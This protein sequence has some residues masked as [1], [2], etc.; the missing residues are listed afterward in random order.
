MGRLMSQR[1]MRKVL[2]WAHIHKADDSCCVRGAIRTNA[3]AKTE[4]DQWEKGETA[5]YVSLDGF[6]QQSNFSLDLLGRRR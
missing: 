3:Q 5:D 6:C 1:L 2:L 4:T